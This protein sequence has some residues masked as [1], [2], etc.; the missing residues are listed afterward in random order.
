MQRKKKKK[1]RKKKKNISKKKKNFRG[2]KKNRR[3][4][5]RKKIFT[6][7]SANR[8]G[9]SYCLSLDEAATD[10]DNGRRSI[11]IAID[12]QQQ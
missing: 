5:I 3:M 12:D 2:N 6:C 7:S 9:R 1:E 11:V 8:D 4:R 10:N